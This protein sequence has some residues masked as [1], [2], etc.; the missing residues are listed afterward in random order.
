MQ[1]KTKTILFIL[2]SFLL[3]ILCGWFLE[4]RVLTRGPHPQNRGQWDFKKMLIERIH[5][6]E[7]QVAQVDTILE[8]RR[9]KME[10]YRKQ[11]FA[12]RDTTRME[13]RKIM[14]AEQSKL[15][16]EYIQERDN[17]EAMKRGHE[18]EK[19]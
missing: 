4:D 1:P 10:V 12:M 7:K 6:D 16:D 15:F 5:L 3:G 17:K 11:A 8:L 13:I 2:L 9:H 18:Q 19:K 14:N